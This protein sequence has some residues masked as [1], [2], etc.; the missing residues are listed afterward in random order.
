M[1]WYNRKKQTKKQKFDEEMKA[2]GGLDALNP[3]RRGFM[4][5]AGSV[6]IGAMGVAGANT[7]VAL[8]NGAKA[9]GDPIPVGAMLP[10]T[11][12]GADDARNFQ[13]GIELA[14]E[15]INEYGGILG[16]PLELH[17]EDTKEI[18]AETVTSAA[19]RLIDRHNVHAIINGYNTVSVRAEYDTVADAGIP[20]LHDNTQYGHQIAVR[21][22]PDRFYC[23]F[24]DDPSE[25][26]YGPGLIYFL[27][28]LERTGKWKRP[29]NKIA[30]FSG[31][32]DYATTIAGGVRDTAPLFGW[33]LV[34]DDMVTQP[35]DDWGPSLVKSRA[36]APALIAATHGFPSDQTGLV[37][38]FAEAPSQSLLYVQYALQL[39]A[40]LDIVKETGEGV[41]CSTTIGALQDEIGLAFYKKTRDRY[42]ADAAPSVAGQVYDSYFTWAIAAARAGGTGVPYDGVE[43]NKKVCHFLR[44]QIYRGVVGTIKYMWGQAATPYPAETNDTS[45]GMP[46]LVMQCQDWTKDVVFVAPEPYDSAEWMN[47]PWLK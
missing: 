39:R 3:T 15:E 45:L 19:R 41:F 43:Q 37:T 46:T 27:D 5:T 28:E 32:I 36:E 7:L 4:S 21:D 16:R 29:N 8:N 40:F 24:Q 17:I 38:G 13:Y 35:V 33:D 42:G 20:Y 25:Y 30:L 26:Y 47:P 1:Q 2:T 14:I 23:I 18:T 10:I 34:I 9:D 31:S 6:A 22:N 11:G 12:W 44:E